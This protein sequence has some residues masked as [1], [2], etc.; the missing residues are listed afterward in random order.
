MAKKYKIPDLPFKGTDEEIKRREEM[1][2]KLKP[3]I[4]TP[5][6][7]EESIKLSVTFKVDFSKGDDKK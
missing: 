1:L 7:D 6:I 2:E 3:N 5:I 4:S